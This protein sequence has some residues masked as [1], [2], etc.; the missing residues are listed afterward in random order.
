[1]EKLGFD[2]GNDGSND[3][4]PQNPQDSRRLS[5]QRCILSLQHACNCTG[6][7]MGSCLKMKRIVQHSKVCKTKNSGC[8]VCKQ[9]IA[10]CCYHAKTC[11]DNQCSVPFCTSI[12]QKLRRQQMERDQ[13]TRRRMAV[14]QTNAPNATNAPTY[15]NQFPPQESSQSNVRNQVVYNQIPAGTPHG[16]SNNMNSNGP[17]KQG[18]NPGPMQMTMGRGQVGNV[19]PSLIQQ[20]SPSV[21]NNAAVGRQTFMSSDI[22]PYRN[23]MR[24]DMNNNPNRNNERTVQHFDP[25]K[26]AKTA[27]EQKQVLQ[28][29]HKN[30]YSHSTSNNVTQNST[31]AAAGNYVKSSQEPSS[32]LFAHRQ[33]QMQQQINKQQKHP[34]PVNPTM[35]RINN[36]QTRQQSFQQ[37]QQAHRMQPPQRQMSSQ[38]FQQ[39]LQQQQSRPQSLQQH[40][41]QIRQVHIPQQQ[42]QTSHATPMFSSNPSN[43]NSNQVKPVSQQQSSNGLQPQRFMQS[44]IGQ[45]SHATPPQ[46]IVKNSLHQTVKTSLNNITPQQRVM[47]PAQSPHGPPTGVTQQQQQSRN[48]IQSRNIVS[49]QQAMS[50]S[51]RLLGPQNPTASSRN[52]QTS[53]QGVP[54]ASPN[55]NNMQNSM[56][57][58]SR[59][60]PQFQ[61]RPHTSQAGVSQQQSPVV[62]PRNMQPLP[63]R[64][65]S[66]AQPMLSPQGNVVSP[67]ALQNHQG[68]VMSPTQ[69]MPNSSVV[70]PQNHQIRSGTGMPPNPQQQVMSPTIPNQQVHAAQSAL[71][72]RSQSYHSNVMP[73]S[74][75]M[76]SSPRSTQPY[77]IG[78]SPI[79]NK[80]PVSVAHKPNQSPIMQDANFSIN[81]GPMPSANMSNDHLGQGPDDDPL[82]AYV[83]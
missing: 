74:S 32:Q 35:Q 64:V 3:D 16:P 28:L 56:V 68:K 69:S 25:S 5:I 77:Q 9:L 70:S 18:R 83:A 26:I 39:P 65:Q 75:Y 46:R 38:Q 11:N 71:S 80:S 81:V 34:G 21:I 67:L 63:Q 19:S 22:S 8:S 49:P 24:S 43:N 27:P 72:P 55:V 23:A 58:P 82:S 52:L 30:N 61:D 4:K 41:N 17:L 12:K 1:M 31:N 42:L 14:M 53:Q 47:S 7:D 45:N 33:A 50:S 51:H 36:Q 29:L 20:P 60:L 76:S 10:L 73:T 48:A 62:S 37:Q 78:A 15:N 2:L 44:I 40:N 79:P 54:H 57:L 59:N 66:P 6:C 13:W